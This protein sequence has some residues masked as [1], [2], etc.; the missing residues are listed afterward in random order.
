MTITIDGIIF[1]LQRQ[2]GISVY[3]RKLLEHLK[4]EGTHA[5]LLLEHPVRQDVGSYGTRVSVIGRRA[6]RLERYRPCRVPAGTSIFHSSYYRLPSIIN[7]PSVVTVH[8]FA[9]ERYAKGPKRWVHVH[10][11]HVAIRA[12]QAVICVSEATRQDLLEFVGEIPGQTVHVIHNGVSE[13]FRPL[14]L[15]PAPAPYVLYVGERRGYKNFKL[16]LAA[17]EFLPDLELHC[18]GGGDLRA[19]ELAAASA[20]ARHRIRHLGFVTDEAL[21][22]HYNRALCLVYPSSYEGF[23]IPVVEAMRAGCPVVSTRCKAVLEV[24]G[25]ALTVAADIEPRTLADAVLRLTSAEYRNQ[26]VSTGLEI[27]RCF[28]WDRTH[29]GTLGVYRSLGASL[30]PSR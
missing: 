18:V 9:Y 22:G 24:G 26:M 27:S 12:A 7:I 23:G 8:D 25:D 19:E 28:S 5:T 11:K 13:V 10:Q 6:R 14:A 30:K 1:S 2:G 4:L 29:A 3:S 20:S 16:L 21:N 15:E 17:M